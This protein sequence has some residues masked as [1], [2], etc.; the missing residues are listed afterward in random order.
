MSPAGFDSYQDLAAR[1]PMPPTHPREPTARDQAETEAKACGHESCT[2]IER[3]VDEPDVELVVAECDD[4]PA[5]VSWRQT[6]GRGGERVGL[7]VE[8]LEVGR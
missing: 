2:V 7:Q 3:R 8:D 1:A 4:C 6:P 5:T